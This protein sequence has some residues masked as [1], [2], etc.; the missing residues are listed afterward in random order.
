MDPLVNRAIQL[1]EKG[2]QSLRQICYKLTEKS[3][4]SWETLRTRVQ[5]TIKQKE[6]HGNHLLSDLDELVLVGIL[7]A[8]D[9]ASI[10]LPCGALLEIVRF[11]FIHDD[12]WDGS[13]S[14]RRFI[15]FRSQINN[16]RLFSSFFLP[17]HIVTILNLP[18][19]LFQHVLSMPPK[20]R[21]KTEKIQ[22][23][24]LTQVEKKHGPLNNH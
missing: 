5:H 10:S 8:F 13:S 19:S 15:S 6:K 21:Q 7:L 4:L 1:L 16:F 12:H 20:L 17:I 18:F 23:T 9:F 11:C 2:D 22:K 3:N 14:F 24:K